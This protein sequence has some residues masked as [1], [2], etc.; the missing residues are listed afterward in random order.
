MPIPSLERTLRSIQKLV[1]DQEWYSAHQKYR[2][3]A[4]R[5]LKS[6]DQSSIR[7]A[8]SLL[9]E[10]SKY[11]Y[12]K[13][14]SGTDLA[15][16]L[17]RDVY[18][19]KKV[20]YRSEDR[21]KVLNLIALAGPSNNW[22]RSIIDA[23]LGWSG[24]AMGCLT[25]DPLIN[26]AVGETYFKEN[27]FPQ[28]VLSELMWIWSKLDPEPE[29]NLA[30]YAGIGVIGYLEVA[31]ILGARTLDDFLSKVTTHHQ[32]LLNS[33]L[34]CP[35]NASSIQIFLNPS[36]N[37]LQLLVITCQ[38]G[39]G[40][41]PNGSKPPPNHNGPT[42]GKAVYQAMIG[43]YSKSEPWLVTPPMK[44]TFASIG[45]IYFGIK[46]PRHGGNIFSDLMGSLFSGGGPDSQPPPPSRRSLKGSDQGAGISE[47]TVD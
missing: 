33:T 46:I 26:Q 3:S 10:G 36:L 7:D 19:S 18:V 41:L 40:T 12:R 13:I 47:P 1:E 30:K 23:A 25:G 9:F 28:A 17:I 4:A 38:V 20:E 27:Q 37:F 24:E 2:T 32:D 34:P 44:E 15:L 5:L 43:R 42:I 45:E 8:I 6:S 39:P 22:R 16:M 21:N 31:S 29:R 14:G 35:N 11:S